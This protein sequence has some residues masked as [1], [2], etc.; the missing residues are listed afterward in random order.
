[1]SLE[2]VVRPP[3][4]SCRGGS[5]IDGM[6]IDMNESQIRTLDQVRA[7]LNG[8]LAVEFRPQGDATG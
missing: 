8:T 7:F 1:M 6:V 5:I 2:R 4:R 3:F